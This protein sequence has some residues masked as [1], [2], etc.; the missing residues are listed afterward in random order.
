LDTTILA[1]NY[2]DGRYSR[3]IPQPNVNI[4]TALE[5]IYEL[6][7]FEEMECLEEIVK[8]YPDFIKNTPQNQI[9]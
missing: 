7:P 3:I 1:C 8:N 5:H 2:A 6:L 4:Q 9:N